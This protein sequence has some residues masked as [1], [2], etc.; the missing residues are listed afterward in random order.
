MEELNV[1][2]EMLGL[3]ILVARYVREHVLHCTVYTF[4]GVAF[5]PFI[6]LIPAGERSPGLL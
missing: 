2:C 5:I 3:E 6:W 4:R 1:S